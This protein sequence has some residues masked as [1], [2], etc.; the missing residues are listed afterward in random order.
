MVK[1]ELSTLTSSIFYADSGGVTSICYLLMVPEIRVVKGAAPTALCHRCGMKARD[2]A[3]REPR[4]LTRSTDLEKD[5]LL[6]ARRPKSAPPAARAAAAT[7]HSHHRSIGI[8]SIKSLVL[9]A[10]T[11]VSRDSK[12]AISLS[13]HFDADPCLNRW[14]WSTV[15]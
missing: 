13:P 8:A 7:S 14:I 11:T 4:D 15:A 9:F 3:L 10:H 5:V 2:F 12:S 6:R 1:I